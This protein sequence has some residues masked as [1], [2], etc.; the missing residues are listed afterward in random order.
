MRR[1]DMEFRKR[2][3]TYSGT[4]E[5]APSERERKNRQIARKVAAEGI[6]LLKNDGILPLKMDTK[7]ALFGGGAVNTIK[8]GTGSGDVNEREVVGI[9]QGFLDAGIT[10]TNREW[11][12]EYRQIYRQAR[13]DWKEKI[14][15]EVAK[16]SDKKF[17][18]IYSTHVFRMPAGSPMREEQV[19]NA[20]VVFYVISRTAGEDADRFL[21]PGDYY[22]T[23]A[24]KA[25]LAYLDAHSDKLVVILNTGGIVDLGDI[26]GLSH[27][28]GLLSIVQP[29]MEGGHALV[30]VLTGRVTP[31]GKLTDT[32]AKAYSDIPDS[33]NYSHNN[34]N[35][36]KEYYTEGIYVGYRYFDS[37]QIETA[38]PF[39]YGL[40]YT[41]FSIRVKEVAV[42]AEGGVS[43]TA[44]V[45]NMGNI[46]SGR[47]VVQVYVSCP[48]M[49]DGKL[50]ETQT[51]N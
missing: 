31:S 12:E 27:L 38:F 44:Q 20:D 28:K 1:T 3:R 39:G 40:S 50:R 41:D 6:V 18:Q 25:A 13:E 24:E 43:V 33:E 21:Q 16:S 10:L 8:G 37:F 5:S 30:D 34:G 46:W 15:E 48:Q 23:E 2:I 32:W 29:G 26:L 19:T 9:Y 47:E 36:Q 35:V 45:T 17:F 22:L 49:L 42:L 7:T 4:T 14:L 11:L 51:A